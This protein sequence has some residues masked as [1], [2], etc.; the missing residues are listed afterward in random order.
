MMAIP[1]PT[2][3]K[4]CILAQGVEQFIGVIPSAYAP[5]R[6]AVRW[7]VEGIKDVDL[8]KRSESTNQG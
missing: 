2:L 1:L 8:P 4:Q 5:D 3:E 7:S 6:L